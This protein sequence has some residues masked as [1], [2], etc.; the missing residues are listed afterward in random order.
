MKILIFIWGAFFV[1]SCSNQ[2]IVTPGTG[3]SGSEAFS[4]VCQAG[5]FTVYKQSVVGA[6][7]Y[8][9]IETLA[10][11]STLSVKGTINS[12]PCHSGGSV[13]FTCEGQVAVAN[14]AIICSSGTIQSGHHVEVSQGGSSTSLL[15]HA[16]SSDKDKCDP[17]VTSCA[18]ATTTSYKHSV[19]LISGQVHIYENGT[20]AAIN[21]RFPHPSPLGGTT[22]G[23]AYQYCSAGF[24]C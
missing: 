15:S 7:G 3:S 12:S 20:K 9:Q 18:P 5:S 22:Y 13:T 16:L 21:L 10:A 6:V 1:L 24:V 14:R 23:G 11:G 2:F 17:A 19:T 8:H 4:K